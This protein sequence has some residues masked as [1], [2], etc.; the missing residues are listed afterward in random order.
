MNHKQLLT[1]Y[2][3]FLKR[4]QGQKQELTIS[5]KIIIE[6]FITQYGVKKQ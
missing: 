2:T 3:L 5:D 1:D 4:Y 6:Q